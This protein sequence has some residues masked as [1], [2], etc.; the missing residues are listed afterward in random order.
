MLLVRMDKVWMDKERSELTVRKNIPVNGSTT[1]E[2]ADVSDTQ[3]RLTIKSNSG[4]F[5]EIDEN[6][7]GVVSVVI[8]KKDIKVN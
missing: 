7:S 8:N 1:L 6:G 3:Y 4:R 5:I 2:I